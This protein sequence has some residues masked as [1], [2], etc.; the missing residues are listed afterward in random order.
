MPST[1]LISCSIGAAT[2]SE[3][4]LAFAPGY[5]VK[6]ITVGGVMLGNCSTGN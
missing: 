3:S 6:T 1:P 2:V 5:D 4:T